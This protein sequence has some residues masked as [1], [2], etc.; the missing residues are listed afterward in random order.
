[1]E[2]SP[3]GSFQYFKGP[4]DVQ[5]WEQCH[6]CG[7]ASCKICTRMQAYTHKYTHLQIP[8]LFQVTIS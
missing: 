4:R 6:L 8:G 7:L 1:M 3:G 2:S 5:L